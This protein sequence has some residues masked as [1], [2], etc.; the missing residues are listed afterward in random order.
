[1][2]IIKQS[3]AI[4]APAETVFNFHTNP[5]NLLK[6]TPSFIKLKLESCTQAGLGQEIKLS[7]KSI[8][9]PERKSHIRFFEYDFPCRLSDM[10]LQGPFKSM[11]QMREFVYDGKQTIMTD[12]FMYEL[13]FGIIGRIADVLFFRRITKKMF[14]YRQQRT[15]ELIENGDF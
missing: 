6:I 4:I 9:L 2:T 13:P 3:V 14:D 1:M 11:K 12:T 15:K 7:I 5:Q 8:G 10:Q